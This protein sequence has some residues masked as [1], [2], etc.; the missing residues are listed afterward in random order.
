MTALQA[1]EMGGCKEGSR[2]VISGGS[3]GV[4]H[5]AIQIAKHHFGA[6]VVATTTGTEKVELCHSL[7]ADIVVDYKAREQ[8]L[9]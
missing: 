8:S 2:V 4:G 3:G 5:L 9:R 1:L 6:A 7:G